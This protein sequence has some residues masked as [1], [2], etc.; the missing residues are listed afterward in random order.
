MELMVATR[1]WADEMG[2]QREF[3]YYLTAE[4]V[5]NG[6]FFCENYG[7]KIAADCGDDAAV[8]GITPSAERI[9]ELLSLLVKN[10]VSPATLSD[11]V[12][13]WL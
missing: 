7:V 13:D 11:V 3:R 1:R 9:D 4:P 8:S 2:L 12:A 6:P 5:E 10:E